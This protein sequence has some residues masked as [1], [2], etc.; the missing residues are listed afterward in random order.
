MVIAPFFALKAKNGEE[1]PNTPVFYG[2]RVAGNTRLVGFKINEEV[3]AETLQAQA[4]KFL[5]E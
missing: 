1:S 2:R 3:R 4:S 5:L